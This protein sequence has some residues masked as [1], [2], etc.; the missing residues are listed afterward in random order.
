[1][2]REIK[3][4]IKIPSFNSWKILTFVFILLFLVSFYFNITGFYLKG[5][6]ISAYPSKEKIMKDV[7]EF[8]NNYLVQPGTRAEVLNITDKGSYYE[9]MTLYQGNYIP[10][11]ISKDGK[12]WFSNV[13][14]IEE[15]KKTISS[16][17]E[18]ATQTQEVPKKDK[19]EFKVFIMSYCPFGIQAVKALLPVM[20]LLGDKADISIHFVNYIMHGEKEVW[21]NLRQYCIQKEQKDK[22]YDYMLC[23]VQSGD[24]EKCIKE[25]NVDVEKLD[26]CISSLDKKYN[27]TEILKDK[28]TWL[29]GVYPPFPV[30]DELNKKYNVGGSPTIIINDVEVRLSRSPEEFKKAICNAFVN[31]P[32]ECEE[33]LSTEIAS[34]GIGPLTGGANTQASCG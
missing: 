34:P 22:F 1:M 18:R 21:E 30:E 13:I 16:Q 19:P 32:K 28:S 11:Y 31:P 27:I 33:K 25:A 26:Y 20:K 15:F 23:F 5:G 4:R 6:A 9:I 2:G 29:N 17:R 14:E 10:I 8:L 3:F 24:Y 7:E 12:V